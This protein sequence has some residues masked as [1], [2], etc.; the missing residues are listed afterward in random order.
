MSNS[1]TSSRTNA[2]PRQN[3]AANERVPKTW[4]FA[5]HDRKYGLVSSVARGQSAWTA[6]RH[7]SSSQ[8]DVARHS[9]SRRRIGRSHCCAGHRYK[10]CKR[11]RCCKWIRIHF[12]RAI[13]NK[14]AVNGLC[15]GVS[16]PRWPTWGFLTRRRRPQ[17]TPAAKQAISQARPG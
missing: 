6:V 7:A 11:G 5:S 8:P 13:D 4:A 9:K 2:R 10:A 1:R 16:P 12:S 3:R 15:L 17:A 14:Y